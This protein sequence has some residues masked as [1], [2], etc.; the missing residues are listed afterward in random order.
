MIKSIM[1]GV[2]F[3]FVFIVAPDGYAREVTPLSNVWYPANP[4]DLVG[5]PA[6]IIKNVQSPLPEPPNDDGVYREVDAGNTAVCAIRRDKTIRCWG[7]NDLGQA[8][9]PKGKFKTISMGDVHGCGVTVHG[10]LRCWGGTLGRPG[11]EKNLG[12]F[13]GV[14][15]AD[16][17]TCGLRTNHKVTCW[18][19]NLADTLTVPKGLFKNGDARS[20]RSCG[21]RMNGN[22]ECWGGNTLRMFEQPS[23]RFE[24]V[25]LGLTHACAIR[26]IDRSVVCWGND[27][28][29]ETQAPQGAFARL[30]A[31][32]FHT[33]GLR[34]DG[35]QVCWG[36]NQFGQ[37]D[38]PIDHYKRI[39]AGGAV[40][41]GLLHDGRLRCAGSYANNDFLTLLRQSAPSSQGSEVTPQFLPFAFL[42]QMA[43]L[44]GSSL[45]NYGKGVDQKWDKQESKIL[46]GN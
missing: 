46:N 27:L 15:A 21:I 18:G 17:H 23:G 40:N 2:F 25:V 19:S 10:R 37:N 7:M 13:I 4:A 28:H 44:A 36:R 43:T 6:A 42:A 12:R 9:P 32:D 16:S 20:E 8:S 26:K 39:S 34:S 33:C 38:L 11:S 22:L 41:C 3:S 45:V 35:S 29:G 24:Q 1:Y 31:G 5:Q 14:L 30:A